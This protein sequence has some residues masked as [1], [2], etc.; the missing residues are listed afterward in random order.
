M[1]TH[2]QVAGTKVYE[3]RR[4]ESL[5]IMQETDHKR[6][7][8]AEVGPSVPFPLSLPCVGCY[9]LWGPYVGTISPCVG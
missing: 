4:E 5:Q 9:I 7:K 8:I 1:D 3:E 6:Q 2:N